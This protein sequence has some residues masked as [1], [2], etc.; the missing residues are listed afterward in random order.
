MKLTNFFTIVLVALIAN[1]AVIHTE[2]ILKSEANASE[3]NV[4][5]R[6]L[7]KEQ[8]SRNSNE[9]KVSGTK[10]PREQEEK[11]IKGKNKASGKKKSRQAR[12]ED[13]FNRSRSSGGMRSSYGSAGR[14]SFGSASRSSY[15]SAS[16]SSFGSTGRSVGRS[17]YSGLSTRGT[18]RPLS[19]THF[20]RPAYSSV[21]PYYSGYGRP[22]SAGY[23]GWP[24]S[25]YYW[26]WR[27]AYWWPYFS[28]RWLRGVY[29][30]PLSYI[31]SNRENCLDIC[32]VYA[33][34]CENYKV[35]YD[36]SGYLKCSCGDSSEDTVVEKY[37]WTP[38]KCVLAKEHG[39]ESI[40]K[41]IIQKKA[42]YEE[43]DE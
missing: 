24:Y 9:A 3:L 30:Y 25:S 42:L 2:L 39:C 7:E 35:K 21:R 41:R 33:A 29:Y 23:L 28:W 31:R 38:R 43:D 34:T 10:H 17:S 20:S 22:Y 15:G 13:S 18:S 36:K 26:G 27:G 16:R 19:N 32:E 4:R 12:R 40:I 14:S 6:E 1:N 5:K 11:N 37:C 8:E